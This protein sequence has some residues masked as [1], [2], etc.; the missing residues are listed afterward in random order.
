MSKNN[1]HLHN[2]QYIEQVLTCATIL[3]IAYLDKGN[4]AIVP[5]NFGY[6]QDNIFFHSSKT[7]S[8]LQCFREHPLVS[9]QTECG[10]ELIRA[11]QPCKV[12][13][14]YKSVIGTGKIEFIE[15]EAQKRH[16]LSVILKQHGILNEN[17]PLSSIQNTTVLRLSIIECS[18]KQSPL[19]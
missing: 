17:M 16:A 11:P 7:G 10:V 15:D 4:P 9:F 8:K 5:V 3:R 19:N 12:T 1:P 13:I 14:H 2:Q 18:Y 6:H